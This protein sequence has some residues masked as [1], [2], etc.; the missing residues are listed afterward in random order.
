MKR[1]TTAL[2]GAVLLATTT[3]SLAAFPDRP[4]RLMVGFAPGGFDIGGRIIAQKLSE[5]GARRASSTTGRVPPGTSPPMLWP[6]A[7]PDGYTMLLFVNSYTINT[8]VYRK[9][10]VGRAS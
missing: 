3:A 4:V 5:L 9:P 8:T 10:D 7:A 6:K 2:L 1:C